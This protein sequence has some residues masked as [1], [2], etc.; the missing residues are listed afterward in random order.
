MTTIDVLSSPRPGGPLRWSEDLVTFLNHT[1]MFRAALVTSMSG[2]IARHF[3]SSADV[4]HASVP[5]T[6][7]PRK[8]QYVLTVKGDYTIEKKVWASLYPFAI[9]NADVVT[10]PS[11][12]LKD[13]IP[14]LKDAH[15]IPNA[16]D[17]T[18]FSQTAL[19][20]KEILTI[21]MVTNFWFENKARGVMHVLDLLQKLQ[22]KKPAFH[23]VVVGDGKYKSRVEEHQKKVHVP[24]TFVGWQDPRTVLSDADIFVYYSDHDNMPNAVLE[25]MACG[26]PVVSNVVG[27]LPEMIANGKDGYIADSDDAYCASVEKLLAN[28]SERKALGSAARQT[29]TDRFSWSTI[30]LRYCDL[31]RQVR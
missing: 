1:S 2:I 24:A 30:V 27:A 29:I 28:F 23:F 10:V 13:R 21:V 11:Q 9:R 7:H 16:V 6:I 31:Y 15:V 3:F 19:R 8:T 17:L 25:A 14:A 22:N 12:Y 18:R 5:L 20:E 26:L 4:V